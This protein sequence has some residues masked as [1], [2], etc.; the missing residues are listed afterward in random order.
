MRLEVRGKCHVLAV[1]FINESLH[2]NGQWIY[3]I[4]SRQNTLIRGETMNRIEC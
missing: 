2:Y 4:H 1:M 3:Y